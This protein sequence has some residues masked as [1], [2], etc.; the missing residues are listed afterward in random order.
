MD[1]E[2]RVK[3]SLRRRADKEVP[4]ERQAWERIS[5]QRGGTHRSARS[6]A[7]VVAVA[8]GISAATTALV[9]DAFSNE[10]QNG[11]V[12]AATVDLPK[13]LTITCAGRQTSADTSL[14]AAQAEGVH[15]R[16]I[17]GARPARLAFRGPEQSRYAALLTGDRGV[18]IPPPGAWRVVCTG[19]TRPRESGGG[20]EVEVIDQDGLWVDGTMACELSDLCHGIGTLRNGD[21]D[22][23]IASI[24]RSV[25]GIEP[26]DVIERSGYPEAVELDG[27]VERYRVVRD[28]R[29]IGSI[30]ISASPVGAT[31]WTA[32]ACKDTALGQALLRA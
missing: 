14:V 1:L 5:Q 26:G 32:R 13:V 8:L 21:G 27:S 30:T 10:P 11:P 29:T 23:T 16:L 18:V 15:V 7:L 25:P 4:D 31:F 19:T 22:D 3:A 12:P 20:A 2:E 24:R 6:R 9:V 28:G 17:G